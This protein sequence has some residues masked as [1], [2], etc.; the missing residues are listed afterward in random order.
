MVEAQ[1]RIPTNLNL[2][3]QEQEIVS[4]S[5]KFLAKLSCTVQFAIAETPIIDFPHRPLDY[6]ARL[7]PSILVRVKSEPASTKQ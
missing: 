7:A 3:D 1:S 4:H 2:C 5:F 6:R